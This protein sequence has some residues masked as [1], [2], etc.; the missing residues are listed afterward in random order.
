[1]HVIVTGVAGFIGFHCARSLLDDGVRVTGID[2]LDPYYDP[3]L[4][5]DRVKQLA[6]PN[7]RFIEGSIAD[8]DFMLGIE[9]DTR[10]VTHVLHL[11]AQAGV[12]YSL[13][14]PLAYIQTNI[15]G[16]AI[17]LELARRLPKLQHFVYASSSSVYGSHENALLSEDSDADHPVSV[18]GATKRADEILTDAYAFLHGLP[19]T[20]L[21]YFTVYGPWGRP[22]MAPYLFAK[23]ILAGQPIKVFNRGKLRRDF[24][25]IDDIVAGTRAA[26]ARVPLA[27]QS[28][29]RHMLYN[30]GAHRSVELIHFIE[31][32]ERACGKE[33]RKEFV[34]MQPGDV[35]E[36]W[37]DIAKSRRDLG[38]EP[39]TTLEEGIPKFVTWLRQYQLR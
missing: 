29:R 1:M 25:Y 3:V 32:L 24:T 7:F 33:A 27:D 28:G 22:D 21:R 39:K 35:K 12:R 16:H 5:R 9:P 30:L 34:D 31:V 19:A 11:A 23:A 15:L 38:Y 36:T 26:L 18:Y 4:K 2:N 17:V 8:R 14:N 20:G 13:E 6:H 37:A 10:D